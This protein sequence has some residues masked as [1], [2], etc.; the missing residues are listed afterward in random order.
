MHQWHIGQ[1]AH[2][3]APPPDRSP[4]AAPLP[5]LAAA[6]SAARWLI[7]AAPPPAHP[8]VGLAWSS[9]QLGHRSSAAEALF[10]ATCCGAHEVFGHMRYRLSGE[11]LALFS[12][13]S[14]GTYTWYLRTHI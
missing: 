2:K 10:Q 14:Q 1:N 13:L 12:H 9:R 11:V 3:I 6:I 8:A 7:L 4:S 5:A